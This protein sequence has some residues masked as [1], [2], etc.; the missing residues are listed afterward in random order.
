[1]A[2]GTAEALTSFAKDAALTGEADPTA[3]GEEE[4]EEEEEEN[5]FFMGNFEF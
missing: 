5:I 3:L 1:M 4:E 2:A